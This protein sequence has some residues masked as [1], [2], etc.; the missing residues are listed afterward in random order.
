MTNFKSSVKSPLEKPR[1]CLGKQQQQQMK[2]RHTYTLQTRP[3][4]W[5]KGGKKITRD[6]QSHRAKVTRQTHTQVKAEGKVSLILWRKAFHKYFLLFCTI[7]RETFSDTEIVLMV[8]I[9]YL[10]NIGLQ[11]LSSQLSSAFAQHTSTEK[12]GFGGT[13]LIHCF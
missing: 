13:P 10:L 7:K 1:C 9:I 4:R 3:F 8:G 5:K 12:V 11:R 2:R 6:C